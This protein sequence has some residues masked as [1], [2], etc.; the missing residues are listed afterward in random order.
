MVGLLTQQQGIQRPEDTPPQETDESLGGLIEGDKVRGQEEPAPE[1]QEALERG[2]ALGLKALT[3][4]GQM[5]RI[6]SGVKK[7]GLANGVGEMVAMLVVEID[8]RLDLPETVILPLATNLASYVMNAVEK[9][10]VLKVTP[11][12]AQELLGAIYT[13]LASAYGATPEDA[14]EALQELDGEQA[15]PK[16]QS[17]GRP[18]QQST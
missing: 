13:V 1:E 17:N 5:D 6:I 10:R 11:E 9:T 3:A 8:K 14:A 4:K 2:R 7:H 12:N 18:T 15:N 16:E